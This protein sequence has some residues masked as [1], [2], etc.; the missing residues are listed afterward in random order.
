SNTKLDKN[1][2][3]EQISWPFAPFDSMRTVWNHYEQHMGYYLHQGLDLIVPIAEPTYSVVP[4]Y[5]KLVLT[6]G[7]ASY[8]RL[9]VSKEQVPGVANGWLHAHLIEST[10]QVDVGDTVTLHE[11]LGDIIHWA[12][13][14]AHIHFVEIKDS[15]SV[16]Y[17]DDNEWGIN[18]NP[19]NA[20]V[21]NT[22]PY[23]PEIQPA[24]PSNGYPLTFAKNNTANILSKDSLY[25]DID[26]IVKVNDYVGESNWSQPAYKSYY[27]ILRADNDSIVKPRTLGHILNHPYSFY[28]SPHFYPYD[29]VLYLDHPSF[30][31][32]SWMDTLRHY[33][34]IITNEDGDTTISEEDTYNS[35]HTTNF[36][37]GNYKIFVE[38]F[39][40]YG[41]SDTASMIVRFKNGIVN[42][43]NELGKYDFYLG[44]NYPNPFNPNTNIEFSVL[45]GG[46]TTIKVYDILG[47]EK[48]TILNEYKPAG[49]YMTS[50]DASNLSSGVY[51]Y[52]IKSGNFKQSKKM[53]LMK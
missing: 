18:F 16:W 13:D 42:V 27:T 26:I 23:P 47:E 49:S 36:V 3:P 12:D 29:S 9:A 37:D 41:N 45:T 7:G 30:L 1:L 28:D 46:I 44:Q 6:I 5:V 17:Y 11:Y 39:D 2:A 33:Y 51:I 20:L 38:V 4:G 15:G 8:W 22:D 52:T 19:L 35:L 34:H 10:I 50:F 43:N 40:Q 53:L 21:P 24:F 48:A 31:P 32:T 25:G 14:W